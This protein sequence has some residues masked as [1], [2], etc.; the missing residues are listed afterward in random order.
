MTKTEQEYFQICAWRYLHPLPKT[1]YGEVHH[2]LPKSCGGMDKVFNLVRLT[3]EEH[4]RCHALLP[5]IFEDNSDNY[6][7]MVY[8]WAFMHKRCGKV[9]STAEEYGEVRRLFSAVHKLN[10][11]GKKQSAET[12]S[13]RVAKNIGQKRSKETCKRISESLKGH[14]GY[15]KGKHLSEDCK[16]KL[17]LAHKGKR[18]SAESR[19]KM[20]EANKGRIPWNKGLHDGKRRTNILTD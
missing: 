1:E 20:S 13:K 9:F 15:F 2:I 10:Q 3:P 16:R 18:H 14:V 4:Y 7:K 6:K 12:I 11:T 8:A 17:S 5:K 19:K